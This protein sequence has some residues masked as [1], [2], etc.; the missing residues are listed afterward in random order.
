MAA[1]AF[2]YILSGSMQLRTPL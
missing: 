2:L 1:G